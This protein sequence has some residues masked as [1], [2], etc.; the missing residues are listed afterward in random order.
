MNQIAPH[1]MSRFCVWWRECK[2]FRKHY[3]PVEAGL[4]LA[5]SS[6][7]LRQ[8]CVI[9]KPTNKLLNKLLMHPDANMDETFH[10]RTRGYSV[11]PWRAVSKEREVPHIDVIYQLGFCGGKWNL[12]INNLELWQ[13]ASMVLIWCVFRR[14]KKETGPLAPSTT[15][16]LPYL[17]LALN[18]V[19][20]MSGFA[21]CGDK[22]SCHTGPGGS[23]EGLQLGRGH[24][25]LKRRWRSC[26]AGLSSL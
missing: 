23:L 18:P 11:K 20:L 1:E 17:S 2:W 16:M 5:L 4:N 14:T 21:E 12:G 24:P 19:N 15:P 10:P 6:V 8:L 3:S 25:E 22:Y 9:Q 7:D 13:K 26:S